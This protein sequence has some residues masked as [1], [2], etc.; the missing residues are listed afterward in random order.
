MARFFVAWF[1]PSNARWEGINA[2]DPDQAFDAG[3]GTAANAAAATLSGKVGKFAAFPID[4]AGK[5]SL[6]TAGPANS[7]LTFSTQGAGSIGNQ[8]RIAYIRAGNNTPLTVAVSGR[9]ITVN[10]ATGAG[11][12]VTSTGNQVLAA[13]NAHA[14]AGPMVQ[15][16]L[17]TGNDGTA[18]VL[19]FALTFLT[20]GTDGVATVETLTPSSTFTQSPDTW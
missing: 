13:V 8:I 9:D 2:N 14:V 19:E 7:N 6:T 1:N 17:A 20:G 4:G 12:A 18:V 16:V 11:G 5:A 3:G 15:A 10:L